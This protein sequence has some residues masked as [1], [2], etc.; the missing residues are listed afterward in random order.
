MRP[1]YATST[2]IFGINVAYLRIPIANFN[3]TPAKY[4]APIYILLLMWLTGITQ[5]DF[6]LLKIQILHTL[7]IEK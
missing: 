4:I 1:L 5:Q 6:F 3:H 2:P 7:M